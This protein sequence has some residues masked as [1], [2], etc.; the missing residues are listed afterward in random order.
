MN[1]T[2]NAQNTTTTTATVN[3]QT[4]HTVTLNTP[5][6]TAAPVTM[7]DKLRA[8]L[9]KSKA[10]ADK[11]AN[12]ITPKVMFETLDQPGTVTSFIEAALNGEDKAPLVILASHVNRSECLKA[13]HA[14]IKFADLAAKYAPTYGLTAPEFTRLL[15]KLIIQD[16]NPASM[17]EDSDTTAPDAAAAAPDAA[18][19]V[20]A[21]Q[22]TAPITQATPAAP[23][24][25]PKQETG[26]IFGITDAPTAKP[27]KGTH[28]A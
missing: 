22:E 13:A 2:A 21:K 5:P 18:A 10:T 11:S 7:A 9:N 26:N 20:E 27:K 3:G 14:A 24:S 1:T 4:T 17:A 19:I 8:K 23:V 28:K 15:T 16:Y 25:E 6:V 12:P